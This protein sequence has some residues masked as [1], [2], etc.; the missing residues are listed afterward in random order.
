[1]TP[2]A[3]LIPYVLRAERHVQQARRSW[4]PTSLAGCEQCS[5]HLQKAI[6]EM[7]AAQ[8]AAALT[9]PGPGVKA[10]LVRLRN[11]VEV[12]SRLVDSATAFS[13]GLALRTVSDEAVHSELRG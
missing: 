6:D 11:E 1:M 9:P 2:E 3:D 13:R 12:L 8:G 10:R 4:D 5:G 7:A